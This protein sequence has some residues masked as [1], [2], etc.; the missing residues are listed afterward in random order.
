LL[1]DAGRDNRALGVDIWYP[2]VVADDPRAVYELLPGI[3]FESAGAH[4]E[5]AVAAGRFPLVLFS[6]G[7][8]GMRFA[9]SLLSEA[10]AARGAVVVSADH[11]GDALA[12]WL[13]GTHVDDRTNEM[14]R[15]G[16]GR[17]LLDSFLAGAG[18]RTGLPDDLLASIDPTRVAAAGHSYGAY[19]A[20]A[21]VAGARGVPADT[22]VGAVIG[23]Q[24]YTRTMSDSALGRVHA[25]TLLVVAELDTATPAESDGDRPWALLPGHPVWRVDLAAA[26]HQAASDMGLYAELA[27]QISDLPQIV[28]DYLES[29]AADAV[30]PGLR[31]WRDG[32]LVQTRALWAFLDVVLQIDEAR[33][34][35]EADR[36]GHVAG[37]SLTRR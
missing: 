15:V 1:I 10:I 21:M 24:A 23:L 18:H 12:D 31:P 36:L 27:H 7:R 9:Y 4:H 33:G 17:F 2:A 25:P 37:V 8:T 34:L 32:L 11:P 26:A 6:H 20:L 19:T 16:D 14:N 30:G 13:L 35:A 22:R 5:P 28:V 3:A 29:T